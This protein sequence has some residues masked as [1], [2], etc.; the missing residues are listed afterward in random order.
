MYRLVYYSRNSCPNL[1]HQEIDAILRVSR[2]N[3]AAG[4]V[5][6]ALMFDEGYFAQVLEGAQSA[7]EETFERIQM[8]PRHYDV[9]IVDFSPV[10][11]RTFHHW[12]MTYT[13]ANLSA[14]ARKLINASGGFD[15]RSLSG[16]EIFLQV[17][18]LVF[19]EGRP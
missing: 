10:S 5:T 15:P 1:G 17:A 8:D 2:R 6:G 14:P 11:D 4:G 7:I 12:A 13:G 19:A 9:Q 16:Q 3:N 18:S